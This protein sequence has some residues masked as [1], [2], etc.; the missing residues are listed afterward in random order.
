VEIRAVSAP[1][2]PARRAQAARMMSL[3]D[4]LAERNQRRQA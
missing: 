3:D 2:P 1:A 4:Y